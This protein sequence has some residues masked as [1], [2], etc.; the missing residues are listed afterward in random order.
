M[1]Q[2]LLVVVVVVVPPLDV[3]V[4]LPPLLVVKN[5]VVRGGRRQSDSLGFLC[6]ITTGGGECPYCRRQKWIRNVK[7]HVHAAR[8][9]HVM[10]VMHDV[11]QHL[12]RPTPCTVCAKV[13]SSMHKMCSH[14][15]KAHRRQPPENT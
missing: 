4:G 12:P 1:D 2:A 3:L 11:D 7:R 9:C 15:S 14:R 5:V 6:F 13:F 10:H 8:A